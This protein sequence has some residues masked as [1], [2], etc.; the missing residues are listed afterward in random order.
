VI[1]SHTSINNIA[2]PA[3]HKAWMPRSCRWNDVN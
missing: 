1:F 3:R 2:F